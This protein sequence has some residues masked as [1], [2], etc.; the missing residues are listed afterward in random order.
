MSNSPSGLPVDTSQLGDASELTVRSLHGPLRALVQAVAAAMAIYHILVLGRFFDIVTEPQKLYGMHLT[1]VV[2]LAFLLIPGRRGS[3][4]PAVVD[5]LVNPTSP[6]GAPHIFVT[7][8]ELT[9]RA[10]GFPTR[11]DVII[12]SLLVIV[13][14]EASRRATGWSLPI[15]CALFA[16]YP[17]VGPYLPGL[18]EH[19]GFSFN[20][21]ISFLFS[22]NGIYGIPIQVSA[23]DASLFILFGAFLEAT[24]IGK[25]IV[26]AALS[27]AGGRRGGPAKVS[28]LT[29]ALFGTASGSSAANVMVDGV[30]NIPLMKATGF[31]ATV[32]GG[33]PAA[34]P[35]HAARR[36]RALGRPAAAAAGHAER[37]LHD[38]LTDVGRLEEGAEQ[39][40]E[41]D[42]PGGDLDGNAV[43]PVVAE[44]KRDDRVEREALVLEQPRQVGP[45]ERIEGEQRAED[46][47]RPARRPPRGLDHDDDEQRPDNDIT[48]CRE[49]PGAAGQLFKGHEHVGDD[50]QARQ[51]E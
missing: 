32:A 30:I 25:Y 8:E 11:S 13:V 35:E 4:R 20:T 49:D 45:D 22:D 46:R 2:V 24:N 15:L 23:R 43:D 44:E 21:V 17:F 6:R 40:E 18:L 47:Q 3:V 50:D 9:G 12:G 38:V 36:D 19:K 14:I 41:V 5:W 1:F 42:V 48:A 7:F 29:S 16:L 26:Q 34:P 39:N 27:V 33:G 51:D 31:R 37:G 10:G 28:I